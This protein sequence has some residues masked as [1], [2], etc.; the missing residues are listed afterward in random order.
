M[1]FSTFCIYTCCGL[2]SPRIKNIAHFL[3]GTSL[4]FSTQLWPNLSDFI[5]KIGYANMAF[6]FLCV[7]VFGG[8]IKESEL[9]NHILCRIMFYFLSRVWEPDLIEW[10]QHVWYLFFICGYLYKFLIVGWQFYC[11]YEDGP[12]GIW[13]HDHLRILCLWHARQVFYQSKLPALFGCFIQTYFT[14]YF[15]VFNQMV[16]LTNIL[17]TQSR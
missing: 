9:S 14:Y 7:I 13:T 4:Y 6:E 12:G 3:M 8:G 11:W 10:S 2:S 1:P 17:Y 5:K 16:S 15:I